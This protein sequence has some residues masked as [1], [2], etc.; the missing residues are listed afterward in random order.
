M[1]SSPIALV[2]IKSLL[3]G[4]GRRVRLKIW[5]LKRSNG[6]SSLVGGANNSMVE[7]YIDNVKVVGSNPS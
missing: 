5:F 2:I 7:Y 3:G 1:G 4:I 6:S